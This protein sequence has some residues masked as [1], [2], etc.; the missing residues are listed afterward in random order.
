M[1]VLI[2]C[3]RKSA[4]HEG[5]NLRTQVEDALKQ[6]GCETQ[7]VEL[8]SSTIRPCAGCF[9]CWVK[10]P[11]LCVITSDCANDLSRTLMRS[12]AIVI[13]SELTYGGF[14]PDIK[15][16]L[17]RSIPN[18]LPFFEIL[19]GEMH[20]KMRYD[21]FPC[22]IAVGYGDSTEDEREIFRELAERNALNLQPQK[23]FCLIVQ[24]AD[25]CPKAV[26]ELGQIFTQEV[27]V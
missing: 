5:F 19:H 13:L 22:W 7:T 2:L 26:R 12:D 18:I 6:A 20:H 15:A 21:R 11:G 10:T 27:C 3:D 9:G 14:S 4:C 8:N 24:N 1:K 25:V 23:H 17:D 16:F